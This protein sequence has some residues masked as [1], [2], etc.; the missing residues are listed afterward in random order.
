MADTQI[1]R[2]GLIFSTSLQAV[3]F[4]GSKPSEEDKDPVAWIDKE[5]GEHPFTEADRSD[6]VLGFLVRDYNSVN[7][8]YNRI[9]FAMNVNLKVMKK[10]YHDK[11]S[12]SVFVNKILDVTPDYYRN[13]VLVRR[14]VLPYFGMELDFKL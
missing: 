7:Y 8:V 3:W 6:A 12:V 13:D 2:L 5:G 10:L 1:P 9:P 4:T 11:V 14:N